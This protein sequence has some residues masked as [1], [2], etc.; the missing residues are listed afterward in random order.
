MAFNL[1]ALPDEVL[2]S[3]FVNVDPHDLARLCCCH[4]LN[5]FINN[6]R[7]L[8]KQSYLKNFVSLSGGSGSV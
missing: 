1:L 7:L 3:I 2:H 4:V 6:D 5:D 8:F